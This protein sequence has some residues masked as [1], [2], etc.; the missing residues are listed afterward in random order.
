MSRRIES[1][2]CRAPGTVVKGS[3]AK[4]R[5][6]D[7]EN[8][9]HNTSES[10]GV[11]V[12]SGPKSVVVLLE[13][14]ILDD[15]YPGPMMESIVQGQRTSSSHEDFGF[16]LTALATFLSNGSDATEAPEGVEI[17]ETNGV[18]GIAEYGG[19]DE[20]ADAGKRGNNGGVGVWL[21]GCSLPLEPLFKK[22]V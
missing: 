16:F 21:V 5:N 13:G 18:V 17:S 10:S 19:E 11:A 12:A 7:R 9:I 14:L 15:G 8:T 1:R 20:G 4:H 2:F 6:G 3:V 22:L